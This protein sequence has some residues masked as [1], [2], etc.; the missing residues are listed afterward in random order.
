MNAEHLQLLPRGQKRIG[1]YIHSY[2]FLYGQKETE[3]NIIKFLVI[4]K[5]PS[6]VTIQNSEGQ[7][8]TEH[9]II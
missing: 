1:N 5:M 8:E 4:K 3:D 6:I 2:T 7:E 9:P